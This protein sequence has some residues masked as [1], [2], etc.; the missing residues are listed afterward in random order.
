M[1]SD[2]VLHRHHFIEIRCWYVC[3]ENL[4]SCVS[5][6]QEAKAASLRPVPGLPVQKRLR[7]V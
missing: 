6:A 5:V 4:P 3:F 7:H 2:I 1:S